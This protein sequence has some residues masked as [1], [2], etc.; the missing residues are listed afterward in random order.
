MPT[1]RYKLVSVETHGG[2]DVVIVEE[3]EAMR[4]LAVYRRNGR[5]LDWRTDEQ[6]GDSGLKRVAR[7]ALEGERVS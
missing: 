1:S 4:R 3:L 7:E 5:Y 2:R 6:V